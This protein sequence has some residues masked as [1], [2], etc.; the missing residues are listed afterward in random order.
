VVRERKVINKNTP[1]KIK[2]AIVPANPTIAIIIIL[3][4]SDKYVLGSFVSEFF[5]FD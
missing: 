4:V 1:P 5:D 2:Q 3:P